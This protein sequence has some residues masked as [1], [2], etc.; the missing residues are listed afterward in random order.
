MRKIGGWN[1]YAFIGILATVALWLHCEKA[2]GSFDPPPVIIPTGNFIVSSDNYTKSNDTITLFKTVCR[3]VDS[4][5]QSEIKK[6]GY[7]YSIKGRNLQ[8]TVKDTVSSACTTSFNVEFSHSSGN[9]LLG[10][11][12]FDSTWYV[13]RGNPASGDSANAKIIKK[14]IDKSAYVWMNIDSAFLKVYYDPD[15]NT[16]ADDFIKQYGAVLAT[17]HITSI[18]PI[19]SNMV[20]ILGVIGYDKA[21]NPL[22][23]TLLITNFYRAGIT[24]YQTSDSTQREQYSKLGPDPYIFNSGTMCPLKSQPPWIEK[25][26][27]NS[28]P[29][30]TK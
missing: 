21:T 13:F 23:D 29:F 4:S 30:K 14:N 27:S 2:T 28:S 5:L 26:I 11:W 22:F 24:I 25:Y 15:T 8:I 6:V 17:R 10:S 9:G 20:E 3:C 12:L 7:H 18:R 16:F 19:K 1:F